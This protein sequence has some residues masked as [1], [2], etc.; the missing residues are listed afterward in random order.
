MVVAVGSTNDTFG[1]PG[2]TENAFFVKT[3]ED[4][5]R[6][7]N[8]MLD[9]IETAN[10]PGQT[11][12]EKRRLLHFV[13]VGGGPTGVETAAEIQ[14]FLDEDIAEYYPQLR[15]FMKVS[16]VQSGDLL[17]NTYSAAI[18]ERTREAF[19]RQNI[20][21]IFNSRVTAVEKENI[22]ILDKATNQ[23]TPVPY[24]TCIWSTGVAQTELAKSLITSLP[25]T[26]KNRRAITTDARLRVKGAPEIFALG[27]CGSIE[28]DKMIRK[29]AELFEQA[30]L[31][32]DNE[33]TKEEV[34]QFAQKV[35][36]VYPQMKLHAK[37]IE[38]LFE[39]FD[40]NKDNV[41][42]RNEFENMIKEIDQ[43][44]TMLPAT[45]QVASQQ[46]K[47]LAQLFNKHL[48]MEGLEEGDTFHYHHMGSFAYVGKNDSVIDTDVGAFSGFAAWIMWRGA[49]LTKQYSF[50]NMVRTSIQ[51]QTPLI[52]LRI[53][54]NCLRLDQSDLLW[55]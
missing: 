19:E 18:S 43:G 5:R 32:G 35:G 30:D 46:G 45:A 49:Y 51:S 42:T 53:G 37:G 12:A 54:G 3:I 29:V 11:E 28:Q 20:N 16:L 52:S 25:E 48:Y 24:G 2:V 23:K 4:A 39:R 27:D 47:Y 33:L 38:T 13:I 15:P 40:V 50:S 31:D 8:H 36:E 7:R 14:D 55:P 34:Y 17:L 10:L 26:Q 22:V 44:L 1:T 41:L 6:L 9:C 21:V